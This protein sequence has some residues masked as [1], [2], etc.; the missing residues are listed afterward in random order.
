LLI[1]VFAGFSWTAMISTLAAELQLFLP[2][3]VMGRE[4]AIYTLVF[5]GCRAFGALL[6]GIIAGQI[7]LTTTFLICAGLSA[8]AVLAGLVWRVPDAG[9]YA[10]DPS[11]T[12]GGPRQ[13]RARADCRTRDGHRPLHDRPTPRAAVARGD[14]AAAPL[15]AA[16]RRSPLGPLP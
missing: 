15:K 5:T 1:A 7:G 11:S 14:A 2:A 8:A 16:N 10:P 6:W 12:G 13:H 3:W 4:M 9:A